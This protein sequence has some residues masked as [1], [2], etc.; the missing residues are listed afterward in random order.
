MVLWYQKRKRGGND[1]NKAVAKEYIR[2][3]VTGAGA[4]AQD[5][6]GFSVKTSN[7]L[8]FE[9]EENGKTVLIYYS[10]IP[11]RLGEQLVGDMVKAYKNIQK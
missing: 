1:M 6:K 9:L 2:V 5:C 11:R 4:M 3:C 7:G 8:T 10:R